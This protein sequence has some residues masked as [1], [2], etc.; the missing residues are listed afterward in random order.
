MEEAKEQILSKLYALRAMLS[1]VC[2][3]KDKMINCKVQEL[4]DLLIIGE[5]LK[6]HFRMIF[7]GPYH[8]GIGYY[9]YICDELSVNWSHWKNFFVTLGKYLQPIYWINYI[10]GDILR[11]ETDDFE[12]AERKFRAFCENFGSE[13]FQ[14]NISGVHFL[15][16]NIYPPTVYN[17][18]VNGYNPPEGNGVTQLVEGFVRVQWLQDGVFKEGLGGVLK[19]KRA[20]LFSSLFGKKKISQLEQLI[21]GLPELQKHVKLVREKTSTEV[22]DIRDRTVILIDALKAEFEPLLD[23]RDWQNLDLIIYYFETRRADTLKEALQLV[24]RE[25]QTQRIQE[26]IM[27]AAAMICKT[28][29]MGFARLQDTMIYCFNSL[30]AQIAKSADAIS[31]QL[32]DAVSVTR[33]NNALQAKVNVSSEQ[34]VGAIKQIQSA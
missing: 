14:N 13:I 8:F 32:N 22:R 6:T 2:E 30:S 17:Y 19:S 31:R 5:K 27:A 28:V 3:E 18:K 1:L 20:G 26:T 7:D 16:D 21:N 29:N 23:I 12:N 25:M 24:D 11:E 34:L 4:K 15:S 10:V 33:M 9:N